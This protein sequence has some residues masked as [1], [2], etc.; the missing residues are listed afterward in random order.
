[1]ATNPLN[2]SLASAVARDAA[3]RD[4]IE[5]LLERERK[6]AELELLLRIADANADAFH[7]G[8]PRRTEHHDIG[9]H[10]AEGASTATRC[11]VAR[12]PPE[13]LAGSFRT[14]STPLRP[15]AGKAE[16]LDV[17]LARLKQCAGIEC[18]LELSRGLLQEGSNDLTSIV[19][20]LG[21]ESVPVAFLDLSRNDLG[22]LG[23]AACVDA[24]RKFAATLRAVA[25]EGNNFGGKAGVGA[26]VDVIARV[27]GLAHLGVSI[28]EGVPLPFSTEDLLLEPWQREAAA[29]KPTPAASAGGAKKPAAA[30]SKAKPA[31]GGK[32]AAAGKGKAVGAT[33]SSVPAGTLAQ[34]SSLLK[35]YGAV[36][37]LSLSQSYLQREALIKFLAAWS[38]AALPA[39]AGSA[40]AAA[41]GGAKAK[42][43][44]KAAPA[45]APAKGKAAATTAPA[46]TSK[47]GASYTPLLNLDLSNC[48]VGALV[49]MDIAVAMGPVPAPSSAE[50]RLGLV[51]APTASAATPAAAAAPGVPPSLPGV[52][53]SLQFLRSLDL[54]SCGLTS[55]GVIPVLEAVATQSVYLSHLILRDNY[56]DDVGAQ[57]LATALQMN[58]VRVE[59]LQHECARLAAITP[60][61]SGFLAEEAPA[62]SP[63]EAE[64]RRVTAAAAAAG[65]SPQCFTP[66]RVVDVRGNPLSLSADM[67]THPGCQA[68]VAA[69]AD[70]PGLL[71]L[72]GPPAS[73][74]SHVVFADFVKSFSTANN[75]EA[76]AVAAPFLTRQDVEATLAVARAAGSGRVVLQMPALLA[77]QAADITIN[78]CMEVL[79]GVDPATSQAG[80]QELWRLRDP[81]ALQLQPTAVS[82]S[83]LALPDSAAITSSSR[84]AAPVESL[85]ALGA[86][87]LSAV[88][89]SHSPADAQPVASDRAAHWMLRDDQLLLEFRA[90][91]AC[92]AAAAR[93]AP[94]QSLVFHV[95]VV[96]DIGKPL[97][98]V[99]SLRGDGSRDRLHARQRTLAALAE[100]A[101]PDDRLDGSNMHWQ[102]ATA[103]DVPR[104]LGQHNAVSSALALPP[105]MTVA[106]AEVDGAQLMAWPLVW[107]CAPLPRHLLQVAGARVLVFAEMVQSGLVKQGHAAPPAASGQLRYVVT[108]TD[109]ALCSD[110][111]PAAARPSDPSA[112]DF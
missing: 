57:A 72:C 46:A 26:L 42:A 90:N 73:V 50:A 43:P 81:V 94:V 49:A 4:A 33:A 51:V 111:A 65:L 88:L 41:T 96:S 61:P 98:H 66:V 2:G 21:A 31:A 20:Q 60:S 19:Q 77:L 23:A 7:A 25:V 27:G 83:P 45:K 5:T 3:A 92:D 28:D 48:N 13:Q 89:P 69:L 93:Y 36:T 95:V 68:L 62:P 74:A 86:P 52:H 82:A 105:S 55:H 6:L 87:L 44:A 34:L 35:A 47:K 8:A 76:G 32:G 85:S 75:P 71:T 100:V 1:M 14:D 102:H 9:S 107:H 58:A 101:T 12:V 97:H 108:V 30:A 91:V 53:G 110:A 84:L 39:K 18:G 112:F 37:S 24:V 103:L 99:V 80:V 79:G 15:V 78:K 10:G 63:L 64:A 106:A 16:L 22:K 38:P 17:E 109:A 104:E 54:S 67:R 56:I 29:G 70:L 11:E 40:A 59:A